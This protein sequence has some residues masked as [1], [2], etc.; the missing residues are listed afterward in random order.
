MAFEVVDPKKRPIKRAGNAFGNGA[1]DQERGCKARARGGGKGID[2]A[3]CKGC[4]GQSRFD[5]A[6][7]MQ[8]VV[9][10]GEFGHHAAVLTVQRDLR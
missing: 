6:A 8:R 3:N 5:Q 7:H 4:L 2:V 10:R 1:A 9:A